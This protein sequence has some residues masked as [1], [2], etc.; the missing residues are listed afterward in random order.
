MKTFLS[1]ETA[2]G[3]FSAKGEK[4]LSPARMEGRRAQ[5]E[6]VKIEVPIHISNKYMFRPTVSQRGQTP[7]TDLAGETWMTTKYKAKL[8]YKSIVVRVDHD[9]RSASQIYIFLPPVSDI[10]SRPPRFQDQISL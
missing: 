7:Q 5:K 6:M 3:W 10:V 9:R 4:G 2:K 1:N 8:T